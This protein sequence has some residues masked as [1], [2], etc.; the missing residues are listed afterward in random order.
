VE[1]RKA[2]N[3]D[4]KR[5]STTQL[6]HGEL[7]ISRLG[8]DAFIVMMDF[9]RKLESGA[10]VGCNVGGPGDVAGQPSG[11]PDAKRYAYREVGNYPESFIREQLGQAASGQEPICKR[12]HERAQEVVGPW[13]AKDANKWFQ[14]FKALRDAHA[15]F[16]SFCAWRA[17]LR[18]IVDCASLAVE[19]W[20]FKFRKYFKGEPYAED[21]HELMRMDGPLRDFVMAFRPSRNVKVTARSSQFKAATGVEQ[22][23]HEKFTKGLKEK[24]D[25]CPPALAADRF[26]EDPERKRRA[27]P[28]SQGAWS[29]YGRILNELNA[30]IEGKSM[31]EQERV[32]RGEASSGGSLVVHDQAMDVVARPKVHQENAL[33][34]GQGDGMHLLTTMEG[35]YLAPFVKAARLWLGRQAVVFPRLGDLTRA[36]CLS[37]V[38]PL[39]K[40]IAAERG[41]RSKS[42]GSEVSLSPQA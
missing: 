17:L 24:V 26:M 3:P 41:P 37:V 4:A 36:L 28:A 29:V 21:V 1:A 15:A 34:L 20:D 11:I 9:L 19:D 5:K 40:W 39:A 12:W 7:A 33:L 8:K 35:A 2:A 23:W 42:L 38:A 30:V 25:F 31:L 16:H 22:A 6:Y 27:T 10:L 13:A 32:A 18:H 14:C